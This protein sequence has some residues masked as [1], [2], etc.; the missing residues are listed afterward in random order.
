MSLSSLIEPT[1]ALLRR[2]RKK[3]GDRL[4]YPCAMGSEGV[5]Q[6]DLICRHAPGIR[7]MTL[8]TGRLPQATY[9]LMD[10]V[11]EHYGIDLEIM[12]PDRSEV[13]TMVREHGLNLFYHSVEYRKL[14]CGI[15]KVNPLRRALTGMEAWITGRRR[16]QSESR[17]AIEPV[18]DDPVFGLIKYNP[19][20]DWR[21]DDIWRYIRQNDVPY[22]RLHDAHYVSI[23]C[24]CCTRAVTAGEDPRAGRWWWENEDTLAECGLHVSSL[25]AGKGEGESGE[26]I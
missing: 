2:A 1:V 26:G 25:N 5:V 12:F 18:E 14:C 8:D 3:H 7:I 11:R 19:M 9:D 21:E 20:L 4:I 23:G 22:N 24:E 16:E 6:I 10:K 17:A 13:E 15:R